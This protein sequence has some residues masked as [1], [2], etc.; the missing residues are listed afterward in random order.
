[1]IREITFQKVLET[2][3]TLQAELGEVA[4]TPDGRRWRYVKANEALLLANA[5]TRIANSDQDT[6]S[7]SA[8]ADGDIT[9]ITQAAAGFT[10]GD[11]TNAYGLVDDGTGSGQ[12]FK[13][14]TNDAT[15]LFLYKDYAL[16]TALSVADSDI[17][18]VRPFLAEKTAVT[19]LNQVPVGVAQVAFAADDFGFVLERGAGV[20]LAGAALV[21]NELAT[22][23]DNTEGTVITVASGETVDDVSSFGRCLVANVTADEGA[24]IDVNLW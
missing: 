2:S 24:M 10:A 15:T 12:F 5:L 3:T 11:F 9:K 16:G 22:P 23:G 8:D 19:T 13:I 4:M 7:S 1:M 18:I 6:V 14:R 21:A 17:V 20:V